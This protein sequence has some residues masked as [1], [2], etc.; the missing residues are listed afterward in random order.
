MIEQPYGGW[1]GGAK[2]VDFDECPEKFGEDVQGDWAL[3]EILK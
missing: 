1:A 3:A 2:Q